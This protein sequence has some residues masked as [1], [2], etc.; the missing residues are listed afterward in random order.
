MNQP[1]VITIKDGTYVYSIPNPTRLVDSVI[2]TNRANIQIFDMT[3]NTTSNQES[4]MFFIEHPD[5]FRTYLAKIENNIPDNFNIY[6]QNI[7][8]DIKVKNLDDVDEY[9]LNMKGGKRRRRTMRTKRRRTA[10]RKRRRTTGRKR[11][12]GTKRKRTAGRKRRI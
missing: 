12:M 1:P 7:L 8:T 11:T 10:G 5:I 4:R 9:W 6:I 2:N 3:N